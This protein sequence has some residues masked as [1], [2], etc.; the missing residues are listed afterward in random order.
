MSAT[1]P[2]RR[3]TGGPVNGTCIIAAEAHKGSLLPGVPNGAPQDASRRARAHDF[4]LCRAATI[5]GQI[6]G[7]DRSVLEEADAREQEAS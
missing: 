3:S 4:E 7:H 1:C 5:L 2:G 6:L